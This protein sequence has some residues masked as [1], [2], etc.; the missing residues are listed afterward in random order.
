MVYKKIEYIQ[1]LK[2][3]F[4]PNVNR[5]S[6]CRSLVLHMVPPSFPAAWHAAA[7]IG[8]KHRVVAAGR[9]PTDVYCY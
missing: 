8:W 4:V 7:A 1:V 5:E 2:Y 3:R 9:V 6:I